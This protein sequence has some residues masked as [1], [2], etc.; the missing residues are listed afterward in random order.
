MG[1]LP[2]AAIAWLPTDA[3]PPVQGD[4]Q[5]DAGPLV[6]SLTGPSPYPRAPEREQPVAP[7]SFLVVAAVEVAELVPPP[8]ACQ[9]EMGFPRL[10]TTWAS[11]AL[12]QIASAVVQQAQC[13]HLR[14]LAGRTEQLGETSA[15]P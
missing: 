4:V 10:E 7:T 2:D 6:A 1:A 13:W 11:P 15:D 3:V 9:G 12:G 5:T 14:Q 8:A